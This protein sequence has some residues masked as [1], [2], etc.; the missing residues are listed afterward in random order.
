MKEVLCGNHQELFP[1]Q[2]AP[3]VIFLSV[4]LLFLVHRFTCD[5]DTSRLAADS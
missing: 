3:R 4:G 1:D 5:G 2:L